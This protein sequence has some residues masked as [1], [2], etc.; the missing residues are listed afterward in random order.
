[1][2]VIVSIYGI[3]GL[4]FAE[5]TYM[6]TDLGMGFMAAPSEKKP[7]KVGEPTSDRVVP[8]VF[9]SAKA[10]MIH[11][12]RIRFRSVALVCDTYSKLNNELNWP[13]AGVRD[14]GKGKH[15]YI[16]FD[17]EELGLLL[18]Q[19]DR[20]RVATAVNLEVKIY[21]P[22]NELIEKFSDSALSQSS[23]LVYKIKNQDQRARTFTL[24]KSYFTGVVRGS[25]AVY[26]KLRSIHDNDKFV[27]ALLAVLTG[28]EGIALRNVVILGKAE[29]DK[30]DMLAR[31][32]NISP[33]DIRYL[34]STGKKK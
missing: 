6:L 18:R 7:M 17:R 28:K 21:N 34:L 32:A 11:Y 1:V 23:T 3:P 26:T 31:K 19:S 22:T 25:D 12:R 5:L 9:G 2:A 4:S 30:I 29:P 20:L 33:F 27:D 15:E 24:V 8:V 10:F 16:R 13:M 14:L